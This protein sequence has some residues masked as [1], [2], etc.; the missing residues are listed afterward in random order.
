MGA[1]RRGDDDGMLRHVAW[2]LALP[3]APSLR[4][5]F[6]ASSRSVVTAGTTSRYPAMTGRQWL[7]R[8]QDD[9]VA[10]YDSTVRFA[11]RMLS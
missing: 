6:S 7:L 1:L 5:W 3:P 8:S 10:G 9:I 4:G 2:L 11:E